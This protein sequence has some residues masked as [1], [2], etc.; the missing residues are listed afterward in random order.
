MASVVEAGSPADASEQL[1]LIANQ[2]QII[3]HDHYYLCDGMIVICD[4]L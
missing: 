3:T 2:A 4:G 1:Y